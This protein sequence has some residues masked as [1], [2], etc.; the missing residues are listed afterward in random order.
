MARANFSHFVEKK[1][2]Y[3]PLN[4]RTLYVS[5]LPS[6]PHGMIA[7][8][9][10]ISVVRVTRPVQSIESSTLNQLASFLRNEKR[11]EGHP[12][13]YTKKLKITSRDNYQ[14]Y[15]R[16]LKYLACAEYLLYIPESIFHLEHIRVEYLSR[17]C[18]VTITTKLYIWRTYFYFSRCLLK[19]CKKIQ[20][21]SR[22]V[23][24]KVARN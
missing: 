22:A 7:L 5:L 23:A 13:S 17:D 2:A 19:S 16:Y 24:N 18:N 12:H 1:S 4:R 15:A 8:F 6:D 20:S 11:S 21:H 3:S 9:R 10:S 14:Y